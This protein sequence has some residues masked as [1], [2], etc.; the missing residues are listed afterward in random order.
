MLY[1]KPLFTLYSKFLCGRHTK[2]PL[3]ILRDFAEVRIEFRSF[4]QSSLLRESTEKFR[5]NF[6]VSFLERKFKNFE[7]RHSLFD[8]TF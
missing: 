7:I 8:N 1:S 5:L 3:A 4:L 2:P 6:R